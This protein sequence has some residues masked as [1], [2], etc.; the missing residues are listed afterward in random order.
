METIS[1]IDLPHDV[2]AHIMQFFFRYC[3]FKTYFNFGVTC[4]SLMAV[5]NSD[6]IWSEVNLDFAPEPTSMY[7]NAAS[8]FG[9]SPAPTIARRPTRE[10]RFLQTLVS[11]HWSQVRRLHAKL[12]TFYV[13]ATSIRANE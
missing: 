10:K 6:T 2:L 12:K 5:A 11:K 4:S 9:F 7:S 13:C 1:L 3:D 8:S